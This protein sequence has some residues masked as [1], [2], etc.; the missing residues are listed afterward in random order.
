M[1][2]KMQEG[3]SETTINF[4]YNDIAF[5][6]KALDQRGEK[7]I[8]YIKAVSK[9]TL[10]LEYDENEFTLNVD[11]KI[12]NA[13][14]FDDILDSY[15]GKLIALETTTLGFVE[16]FYCCKALFDKKFPKV[17][18]LYLEPLEYHST[19]RSKLMH[20]HDFDLSE[21]F[22]GFRAIPGA[23][24][25]LSDRYSQRGVFL[26]GFEERRLD[27]ALEDYQ[28]IQTDKC[29]VVFGV[30][31]F[32]AGWE[33]NSFANNI[34]VIRDKKLKGGVHF[35]GANN[36]LSTLEL[37][38]EYYGILKRDERMFISPIGTKPSGIGTVLFV[39][40]HRDVGILY[41]HPKQKSKR[42]TEISKWH[43]FE[44]DF[45]C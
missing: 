38:N 2:I 15:K 19:S 25:M 4:P 45:K 8:E 37:L 22:A 18:L 34:R 3:S 36:P 17:T 21:E 1:I 24:I 9:L 16:I 42:S 11:G 14:Y 31:A 44:V 39:L 10:V 23:T 20:R 33:M 32:K 12:I 27:R 13:E 6:G 30:P 41:D 29:T 28:M 35:C 7:A 5:I 40:D 43:I 26:L